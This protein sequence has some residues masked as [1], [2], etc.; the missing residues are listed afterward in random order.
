MQHENVTD[1]ISHPVETREDWN[2]VTMLPLDKIYAG[3]AT[4]AI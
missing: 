2:K 3:N 1:A 4:S